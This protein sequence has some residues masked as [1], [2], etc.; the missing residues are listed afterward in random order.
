VAEPAHTPGPW[1]QV[2][3][4]TG[5]IL[6]A[7]NGAPDPVTRARHLWVARIFP[8]GDPNALWQGRTQANIEADARVIQWAPSMLDYLRRLVTRID[9]AHAEVHSGLDGVELRLLLHNI[10][11]TA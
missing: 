4:G 9:H 3:D 2:V 1:T 8:A 5:A 10:E 6:I 11:E 7:G